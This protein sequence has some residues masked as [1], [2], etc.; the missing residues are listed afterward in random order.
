MR[1]G[2]TAAPGGTRGA[3]HA[4]RSL[5]RRRR[6]GR[7]DHR[8]DAVRARA[9]QGD[10]GDRAQGRGGRARRLRHRRAPQPAVRAL[11][12]HHHAR[13]HRG[14][15]RAAAAV[16][17]DHADHHQRPGEDRRGL[18]DAPAP[19]RRPG[20]PD[21]GARQHRTGLPVVRPG[22]PQRHPAGHRELRPAAPAVARGR[23]RLEGP[24]PHPA[25]V[26][27]L[28]AA[29]ARRRAAVR[30]A[31]LDPQPGDRRA[32][33]VLRR[34][35]LRQP[36]LLAQGAHPADG[37]PLPPALR[38]LRPR[39]RRPGDRRARRAGVHA[40]ELAGRGPRVP[41]VLRQ[42][43]GLRARAVAGGVHPGDA[44]DRRQPAAGHRPDARLPRVRRRLPAPAL[45]D[46]PRR[47]AAEDRARAARPARRGG[48]PGAAQGV[49]RAAPAARAR[50][51][52]ARLAGR[53]PRRRRAAT[54][55]GAEAAR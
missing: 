39:H 55:R 35:L 29:P 44:A 46:R 1:P 48:R 41:A 17:R 33:R 24:L 25:A 32:G 42:R 26:V 34:R 31:R 11:V 15:H 23:G 52:D 2:A 40:E 45:P 5:H 8:A 3:G 27:H 21:D 43:P 37:R 22:H 18:R 50:G 49:R 53:G 47:A 51:A 13:L 9:D 20:R 30:L 4:V 7:S 36:H 28:D 14:P 10:G 38:A 12:A 19:G 54:G 16:H 6:H